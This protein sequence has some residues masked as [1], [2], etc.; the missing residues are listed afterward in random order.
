[1]FDVSVVS[2]FTLFYTASTKYCWV[3]V[4]KEGREKNLDKGIAVGDK[5]KTFLLASD[6][7]C[8]TKSS[9]EESFLFLRREKNFK[10][11]W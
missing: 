10:H 6:F 4:L 11:R 2:H 1:M 9:V 5:K 7:F 8:Q 3:D